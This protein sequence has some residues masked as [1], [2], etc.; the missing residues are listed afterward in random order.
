MTKIELKNKL[1]SIDYPEGY[2]SLNGEGNFGLTYDDKTF[3]Q[4][5]VY[6]LDDRGG[7]FQEKIFND[8]S[9]TCE[10]MYEQVSYY[11][12]GRKRDEEIRKKSTR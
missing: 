6:I 3:G 4:W 9:S 1:K 10:Y 11:A 7:R 12:D 2:Y 5:H 8:E